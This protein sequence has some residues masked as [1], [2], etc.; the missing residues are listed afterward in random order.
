MT[1]AVPP[2]AAAV[3]NM[4]PVVADAWHK[5]TVTAQTDAEARK[6]AADCARAINAV[7]VTSLK[8]SPSYDSLPLPADLHV[9][10]PTLE[11]WSSE[12]LLPSCIRLPVQ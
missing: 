1:L 7:G 6:A 4:T 11:F 12:T 3:G 10:A 9:N 8:V 5:L 2:S